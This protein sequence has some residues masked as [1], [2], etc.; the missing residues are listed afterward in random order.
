MTISLNGTTG[1][2]FPDS[3]LQA[4]AASPYVLKNRI[5]NGDMVI[6]QRNAGASLTITN[7]GQY[8][9][10]RW[11]I[12]SSQSSKL[13]IQQNAGSVTPPA[14]FTNYA[15]IT[16]LAATTVG[17]DA[18]SFRQQIEGYN[19]ADLDWG[20]ANAKTITVSFWVR[21]SLTGA[22]GAS[23]FN[24][25]ANRVY[26]FS[27]TIASA[28]TWTQISVTIPGD[29]T[30]TWL[31][32]NGTGL[33]LYFGLG[34]SSSISGTANVW[35]A[36]TAFVPTGSTNVVST[37]GATFYITGVQLEIGT[38][39]TPF[40]RR[41]YG[42]ELI[43]CQR[44]YQTQ[45]TDIGNSLIWS[46]NVTN[47]VAYYSSKTLQVTMRASPTVTV[48][49]ELGKNLF[50]GAPTVDW[51]SSDGFRFYNTA[52]STNTGG[53]FFYKWSASIEL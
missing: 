8:N 25:A 50:A 39:A 27:Y 37:N 15:G 9:L 1:I 52:N 6:D 16:S 7:N 11:S 20:T 51:A 41:L 26:P 40:E 18:Y 32:T 29:T 10:D 45:G 48:G 49:S 12:G 22:F 33:Y 31:T 36:G 5:I 47:G 42:Q 24:S 38:S 44:Y 3:S 2:Q 4:A 30:G 28:N 46:G 23:I 13:S 43:N 19:I 14:G 53:Y 34:V 35:N 17:A 21:S